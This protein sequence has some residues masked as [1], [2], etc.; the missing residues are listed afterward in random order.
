M[1]LQ[2]RSADVH[3]V[4]F[5]YM[6][7]TIPCIT[8]LVVSVWYVYETVCGLAHVAVFLYACVCVCGQYETVF[9]WHL[10]L[11]ERSGMPG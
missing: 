1:L 4:S 9:H 7:I 3:N 8:H 2:N 10:E 11:K 6:Y 5:Y